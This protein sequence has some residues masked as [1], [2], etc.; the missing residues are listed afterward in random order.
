M[1]P[2]RG[3]AEKKAEK[4]EK[5]PKVV[6]KALDKEEGAEPSNVAV[7]RG[8]GSQPASSTPF[9]FFGAI[10]KTPEEEE[11]ERKQKEL[12]EALEDAAR[13]GN[14]RELQALEAKGAKIDTSVACGAANSGNV[15]VIL[16]CCRV[17]GHPLDDTIC[18]GVASS[19]NVEAFKYFVANRND[20]KE[21]L[22]GMANHIMNFGAGSGNIDM[23]KHLQSLGC[24]ITHF[25]AST[26]ISS[27]S[28][29]AV[30]YCL[31]NGAPPLTKSNLKFVKDKEMIAFIKSQI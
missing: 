30:K 22:E 25:T 17:S 9:S 7:Q 4:P 31:A 23:I 1:P 29:D 18:R 14:L 27:G 16:Y 28:I 20:G 8:F 13:N 5:G 11:A 21:G 2:K 26:A 12:K 10:A 15:D 24:P 19:G 3:K 6:K